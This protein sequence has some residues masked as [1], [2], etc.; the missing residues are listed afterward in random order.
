MAGKI[1]L[2]RRRVEKK[3]TTDVLDVLDVLDAVG[4]RGSGESRLNLF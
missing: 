4:P 3:N 2:Y 1:L